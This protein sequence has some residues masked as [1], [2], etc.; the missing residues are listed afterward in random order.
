LGKL[1]TNQK[2]K[3]FSLSLFEITWEKKMSIKKILGFL[4]TVIVLNMGL[5][6]D[7]SAESIRLKCESRKSP[8]RAKISVDGRGFGPGQYRAVV[9]SGKVQR[10]SRLSLSPV[11]G[12]VEF[13][14]DSKREDVKEGATFI[15]PT[16]IKNNRVVA[17]IID[18]DGFAVAPQ[19]KTCRAR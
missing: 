9:N 14:F 13:D 5:F 7:A 16:F 6:T 19:A 4:V 10:V 11:D 8:P 2:R 12:E 3:S 17:T 18:Q 1:V 15:R